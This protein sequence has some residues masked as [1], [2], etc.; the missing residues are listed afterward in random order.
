MNDTMHHDSTHILI[1][2]E[3]FERGQYSRPRSMMVFTIYND[4]HGT[5]Y[6]GKVVQYCAY[7]TLCESG[8]VWSNDPSIGQTDFNANK[9]YDIEVLRR[10]WKSMLAHPGFQ[11]KK[12]E[13]NSSIKHE[14]EKQ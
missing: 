1:R 4:H 7:Q 5:P 13:F 14:V 6:C 8:F 9:Y 10:L 12:Y 11:G 2:E 3:V